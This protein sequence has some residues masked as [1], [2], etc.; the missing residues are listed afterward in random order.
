M[1]L[2]AFSDRI[3]HGKNLA[4]IFAYIHNNTVWE[5]SRKDREKNL[6]NSLNAANKYNLTLNKEKSIIDA[7]ELK[8]LDCLPGTDET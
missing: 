3:I 5:M 7:K 1:T 4:G 6:A 2:F 8:L